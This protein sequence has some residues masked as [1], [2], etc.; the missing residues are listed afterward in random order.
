[1]DIILN[2]G[3]VITSGECTYRILRCVGRGASAVAYMAEC[4]SSGITTACILKEYNPA[5]MAV[6]RNEDLSLTCSSNEDFR[7]GMKRFLQ[8]GYRQNEI[9]QRTNMRNQTPP[10]SRIFEA[11]GTAYIDV[12]CYDGTTLD[13]LTGLT[14]AEYTEILLSAA[15]NVSACHSSGCL[16]LDLKPENIFVMLDSVGKPVTQLVEFIDF[17][18][19][20][21][22]NSTEKYMYYTR[23]WA[24]PE[25]KDSFSCSK[26]CEAT[27]IYTLG[28]LAFSIY[29]GRHS[30]DSEH[31]GFSKY[32][33]EK[34]RKEYRAVLARPAVQK[35][36]TKLFRNTLRP[37]VSNRFSS[38]NDVIAIFEKLTE[39]TERKDFV[40]PVLPRT[41][42]FFTGRNKEINFIS[43]NL[44]ENGLVWLY[45]T[46]GIG[47]ST[48]VRNYIHRKKSEYDIVIYLEFNNSIISTFTDDRQLKISTVRKYPEESRQEYFSRKLETL[49]VICSDRD[50]LFVVDNFE[51]LITQEFSELINN[52][53]DTLVVSRRTPPENSFISLE[54]T[55][56][57]EPEDIFR[58]ISLN[59]GRGLSNREKESFSEIIRLVE[60]HTLVLELIARQ[61]KSE[62]ISVQET[63]ELIEENGFSKFSDEKISN[64]KDNSEIYDT[65]SDI[66]SALF[67]RG[68]MNDRFT[69]YM[70]IL[71]LA[72]SRGLDCSILQD[73][74]K[75]EDN[76]ILK[77]LAENGWIYEGDVIRVHPVI[78]ETVRQ[79][80]WPDSERDI[81]V[82]KYHKRIISVYESMEDYTQ[83]LKTSELAD[84]Y[85]DLHESGIIYAMALD[86][87]GSFYEALL[88]GAYDSCDEEDI[89]IIN[90]LRETTF[91]AVIY[92]SAPQNAE[93]AG[94]LCMYLQSL[95]S[96]YIRTYRD[97]DE[98]IIKECI[99]RSRNLTDSESQNYKDLLCTFMMVNAWYFTKIEPDNKKVH[100]YIEKAAVLAAEAYTN[101][102]EL[103]DIFYIPAAS[104]CFSLGE[105]ETAVS[106]L[107]EA[108]N[109]CRSHMDILQYVDK[110]AELLRCLLDVYFE[111]DDHEKCTEL[112]SEINEINEKYSSQGIYREI[113]PVITEMYY[114]E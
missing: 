54:V 114:S 29:F 96:V 38:V 101:A 105:Y 82:M 21:T 67:D 63:L 24:A 11:N 100:E 2:E 13:K 59:L 7:N 12:T 69:V 51:G 14:L 79:W 50:V 97:G 85:A 109:I 90:S 108:A 39:E 3:A 92:A 10:V 78:A 26:I 56:I 18:S 75:L 35:L 40:V 53:W 111:N 57:S 55:A 17:N 93:E 86:M 110:L 112:I 30:E 42:P 47:K 43:E 89:K 20:R 1:M 74:I 68:D 80:P 45:G 46:G 32:D 44:E 22:T 25:Q 65:L 62:N 16:C 15:K 99:N 72:D 8:S 103:I 19:V 37:S 27:D 9:R 58:L 28:E 33:F 84:A 49:K 70:K 71:S 34:C 77:K 113:N 104:C 81:D 76:S 102:L 6:S 48:I 73:I 36:L 98:E 31:R 5:G 88:G 4:S 107:S 94:L 64:Y 52:G 91:L 87:T 23:E 61:I 83:I 95:A 60:G 106:L 41:S 66:I